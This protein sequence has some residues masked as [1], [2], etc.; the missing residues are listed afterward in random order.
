MLGDRPSY[1]PTAIEQ[2]QRSQAVGQRLYQK[3]ESNNNSS[4]L[5][6]ENISFGR[7]SSPGR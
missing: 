3:G 1:R 2:L 4:A 7:Q 5:V 6:Q